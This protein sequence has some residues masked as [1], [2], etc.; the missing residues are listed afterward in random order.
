MTSMRINMYHS[1]TFILLLTLVSCGQRKT[2]SQIESTDSSQILPAVQSSLENDSVGILNTFHR[3]KMN[4][5]FLNEVGLEKGINFTWNDDSVKIIRGDLD[6]DSIEDALFFFSIDGHN[7]GNNWDSYYIV[8]LQKNRQ[9][10]YQNLTYAGGAGADRIIDLEK[11]KNGVI[12][13]NL[14]ANKDTSLASI[15][16]EYVLKDGK[17]IN[18]FTALHKEVNAERE[19]LVFKEILTDSNLQIPFRATLKEYEQLLGKGTIAT[20]KT[21][22]D[23][24]T[25]FEKGIFSELTYPSAALMIELSD[26]KDGVWRSL[27]LKGS[28]FKVN[29]DKGFI[30][31][32]TTIPELQ[33][34]FHK[35]ESWI[36]NVE[37]DKSKTFWIPD[38]GES[39]NQIRI[40]FDKEGKIE[41]VSLFIPC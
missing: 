37:K 7:G 13:G 18:S 39:D 41:S 33:S 22:P 16:I 20:P 34:V 24:G 23:C 32:E 15:P 4:N 25:Y 27:V 31:E 40:H 12:S 11:I 29:T 38:G 3:L 19:F 14:V 6:N 21:Q 35:K 2:S 9:W 30:T 10:I 8:F 28:R 26:N 36:M 17:M 5:E 1:F